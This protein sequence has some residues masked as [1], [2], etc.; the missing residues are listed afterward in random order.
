M[1]KVER[2][3]NKAQLITVWLLVISVL[4]TCAYVTIYVIAKRRAEKNAGTTDNTVITDIRDGEALSST[5]MPLAYPEIAEKQILFV[6]IENYKTDERYGI[7]REPDENNKPNGGFLFQYFRK[8]INDFQTYMPPITS[9][10][11]N[12]NYSDLYA[13]EGNDGFGRI[14]YITY[15]CAALGN[16]IFTERIDIPMGTDQASEL[17]RNALYEDCGF[18]EIDKE[19]N[20]PKNVSTEVLMQYCQRDGKTNDIIEGTEKNILVTVGGKALSGAGFYFM[21]TDGVNDRPYIYYTSSEYLSYALKSFSDYVQGTLVSKG[22]TNDSVYGPY[23]T[24]EFTSWVGEK[25][26]SGE[27]ALSTNSKKYQNP[28]VIAYGKY[29]STM[30]TGY[31][32]GDGELKFD[33]EAL[34]THPDFGRIKNALVGKSV[35][36]YATSPILLTLLEDLTPS[37][38]SDR[39]LDFTSSESL[40]YT[41]TVKKIEAVITDIGERTDGTVGQDDKLVKIT[42]DLTVGEETKSECHA[43]VKRSEIGEDNFA[44]FIGKTVGETPDW[45]PFD[46]VITYTRSNS[47]Q[48]RHT[49]VLT[50]VSAIFDADGILTD[51]I[52]ET[53]YVNITYRIMINGQYSEEKTHPI[54]LADIGEK[55]KL[56]ALR[57]ILLGKGKGDYNETIY[58]DVSRYE[59]MREFSS[60]EISEIKYFTV[61]EIVVSF[62]FQNASLRNPYYGESFYVNKLENEN[63]IYGLNAGSCESVVKLLG[64]I[65]SDGNS[66]VGI[67]GQTVAVGLTAANMSKYGLYAHKIYFEMPR[68]IYDASEGTETDSD[69]VLSDFAWIDTIGF[70]LYIS[71]VTYDEDGN[72]VRYIGSDMY[73]VVTKVYST[74]FDFVEYGFVEF[75][76]RKS[77]VMMDIVKLDE[78]KLE[79]FMSDLTGSYTFDVD[80]KD[81]YSAYINGQLLF[82]EEKLDGYSAVK[83]FQTVKVT[84][85]SDAFDT[86][87]TELYGES[88][89]DLAWLYEQ[90][91]G[92]GKTN[93]YPGAQNTTYGAAYFNSAYSILQL[94][95]YLDTLTEEEQALGFSSAKVMS[96]SIKVEGLKINDQEFYYT[97][98]FYR[99]DDRR[100]MV[101][102]YKTNAAGECIDDNGNTVPPESIG[103]HVVSDFYVDNFAFKKLVNAYIQLLNGN[104][105]DENLGYP[106]L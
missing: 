46:I 42:Y 76:T 93:Y 72:R 68:L 17:K 84:A 7:F 102:L 96:M 56:Y 18:I 63:K 105:F 6:D 86:R 83:D 70:T 66:A 21:V 31:D 49:Y 75:W 94:I 104:K 30:S 19:T 67:S 64:G 97:Y 51:T 39:L 57:D 3:L 106:A 43:V 82:S 74:D 55:H 4:L 65:G 38:S 54:R 100:I 29:S 79:F 62:A 59:Y 12:F 58:D 81:G 89:A 32:K 11:P 35:G 103:E 37:S 23:L 15:L 53:C 27:I 36:S 24:T 28:F 69:D 52:T 14:Y 44:K 71:D 9:E 91:L 88:T 20:K 8:D 40:T 80:F 22:L 2:K 1:R 16:P 99:I 61:N 101:A 50:E 13:V 73:D 60:Y 98:D 10:D 92:G 78:L 41:Y 47:L 85:S 48:T 26:T 25:F 90:T 87:F 95:S 77:L 5:Y 33:L 34:K 45:S